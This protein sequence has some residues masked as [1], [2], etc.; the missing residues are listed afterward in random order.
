MNWEVRQLA[1]GFLLAPLSATGALLATLIIRFYKLQ[2][3][4]LPGMYPDES[5]PKMMS[6]PATLHAFWELGV[7][8]LLIWIPVA[9]ALDLVIRRYVFRLA[10]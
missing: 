9:L 6:I 5:W 8:P 2:E 4:G 7:S 1:L 10:Q 3:V